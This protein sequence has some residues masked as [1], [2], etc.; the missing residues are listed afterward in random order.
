LKVKPADYPGKWRYFMPAEIDT[1]NKML[2][3]SSKTAKAG[4]GWMDE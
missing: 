1:K 2:T 3:N 4:E